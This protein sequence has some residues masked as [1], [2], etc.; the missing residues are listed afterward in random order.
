MSDFRTAQAEAAEWL[1]RGVQGSAARRS[2]DCVMNGTMVS[3][4][5]VGG[6][7]TE[8]RFQFPTAPLGA[9]VSAAGSFANRSR[10][11]PLL[12]FL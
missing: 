8:S 9:P 5:T 2:L 7:R 3:F 4:A 6:Q 12:G 1:A 11:L 10:V